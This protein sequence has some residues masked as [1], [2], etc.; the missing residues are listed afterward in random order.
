M[1]PR[2]PRPIEVNVYA[3]INQSIS[4]STHGTIEAPLSSSNRFKSMCA[5][6]PTNRNHSASLEPLKPGRHTSRPIGSECCALVLSNNITCIGFI[7][8]SPIHTN[9]PIFWQTQILVTFRKPL[10]PPGP[11]EGTCLPLKWSLFI[12]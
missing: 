2:R 11:D 8:I 12:A 6:Q 9:S 10:P 3:P 7:S 5:H 4:Q 1:N